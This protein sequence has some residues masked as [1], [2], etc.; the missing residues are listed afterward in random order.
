M[1]YLH[2]GTSFSASKS[3]PQRQERWW[4]SRGMMSSSVSG[5]TDW[6]FVSDQLRKQQVSST[7]KHPVEFEGQFKVQ[8]IQESI[9]SIAVRNNP[10]VNSC[11]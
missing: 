2:R 5:D 4:A 7:I 1:S 8:R 10:G 3:H 6:L 11:L 9:T